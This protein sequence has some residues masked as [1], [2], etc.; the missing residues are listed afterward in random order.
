MADRILRLWF[1]FLALIAVSAV[2]DLNGTA[3]AQNTLE[4]LLMPGPVVSS[5]AKNEDNCD[6]CHLPFSKEAQDNLCL[7][8]HKP[9]KADILDKKGFHGRSPTLKGLACNACH[10]DHIGRDADIAPFDAVT[11]DHTETDY[12]LTGS[13]VNVPCQDCHIKGKRWAEAPGTCFACHEEDQ[14][15]KGNLGKECQTCHKVSTWNETI[16]F[17]HGKTKFP[18]R[19]KHA[20]VACA[21]CHLGE[22]YKGVG[23]ACNDC[24]VIQDIHQ[25]R[26]ETKCDTCHN[27]KTWKDAKFDHAK[28]TRFPLN[29]AHGKATCQACHGASVLTQISTACFDCHAKQDIHK[30]QL[31]TDCGACHADVSWSKD[32]SFDHGLT[33]FPLGGLHVA[34]ACKS[35]HA[36]PTFKD[37]GLACIDCHKRDDVHVG[38]F[39]ARCETCHTATGW[40]RVAFDH[41]KQTKFPLTGKH[42][43]TGCNNCHTK[44][45]VADASLPVDCFSCHAKQDVH[46]GK[47]GKN[48]AQCHDTTTFSVAFIRR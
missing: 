13:H 16:A 40:T 19:E 9:I 31:G 18:L 23:T 36:T 2:G 3:F 5:H 11:F 28:D 24:H 7:D 33:K 43:K 44:K 45:N 22:I 25:Q 6:S 15:H 12:P 41:G 4:R 38:R 29:G 26:F 35:C 21:A 37:A 46:R 30:A 34:V 42:S 1:T 27:E 47:F 17:D 14:P 48:C 10:D 8:C 20:T 32:I 39:T